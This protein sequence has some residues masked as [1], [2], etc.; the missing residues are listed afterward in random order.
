ML[1]RDGDVCLFT[2]ENY[3]TPE[4]VIILYKPYFTLRC[5]LICEHFSFLDILSVQIKQ[6]DHNDESNLTLPCVP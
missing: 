5:L 1:M 3:D 4:T 6:L 2:C